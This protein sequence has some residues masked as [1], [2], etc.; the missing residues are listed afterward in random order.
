YLLGLTKKLNI[1]SLNQVIT[2]HHPVRVAE[3]TSLIDQ[4]SKGRFI[5]GFSDSESEFEMN[6]FN[7]DIKSQRMI[8]E[9]CHDIIDDAIKTGYCHADNDFYNFPKISVNPHCYTKF[10]PKQYVMATSETVVEWAARKAL[11][12]T[13]KWDDNLYTKENYASLYNKT[14]NENNIDVSNVDHQLCMIVNINNDGEIARE[15]T[16]RY[17]S[18]YVSETYPNHNQEDKI[19]EIIDEN[20]IGTNDDYYDSTLLAIS[21]TG[22]K[23][24]LLSFESM[25]DHDNRLKLIE[26]VNSKIERNLQ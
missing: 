3:E 1:G 4:M 8:F 20:A 17:L 10:G 24:I 9:A 26:F 23:R 25:Q 6:F 21:K 19:K 14:A 5:L 18:S 16:K 12:L 11:P 2:T 22:A 7:R 15:E 13:F